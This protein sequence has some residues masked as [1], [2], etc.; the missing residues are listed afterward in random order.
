M[1]RGVAR[2]LAVVVSLALLAPSPALASTA[3]AP[4]LAEM[5]AH[6]SSGWGHSTYYRTP[7]GTSWY[8]GSV[9]ASSRHAR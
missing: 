3:S 5:L 7:D 9:V 6:E 2:L 8:G 4:I 1:V